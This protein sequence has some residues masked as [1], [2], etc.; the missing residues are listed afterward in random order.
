[1]E[2]SKLKNLLFKPR[3]N[4]LEPEPY[5]TIDV[6]KYLDLLVP[7]IENEHSSAS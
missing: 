3:E 7:N 5:F 2:E 1:M 6:D 4:K